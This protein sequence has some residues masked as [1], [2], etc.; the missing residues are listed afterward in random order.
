MLAKS[1]KLITKKRRSWKI[2]GVNWFALRDTKNKSTCRFCLK[3]GLLNLNGGP[4]P[5]WREF[6]RFA[7]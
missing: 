6:K 2:S 5:A 4:K 3:S 7:K 1:F